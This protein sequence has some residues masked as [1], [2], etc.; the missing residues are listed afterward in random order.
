[1]S[2]DR[3]DPPHLP[4]HA[5]ELLCLAE[6]RLR[7]AGP[8][9]GLPASLDIAALVHN[10]SQLSDD[11]LR[12]Q[13]HIVVLPAVLA[14][15]CLLLAARELPVDGTATHKALAKSGRLA[16]LLRGLSGAA[17]LTDRQV[18]DACAL[19]QQLR[20]E[21][22]AVAAAAAH[23]CTVPLTSLVPLNSPCAPGPEPQWNFEF[24]AYRA[25]QGGTPLGVGELQPQPSSRSG[26]RNDR[27]HR[28]RAPAEA[29][30]G[31]R[32]PRDDEDGEVGEL[33]PRSRS[34]QHH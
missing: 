2:T 29:H 5:A 15:A 31:R 10:A 9:W 20:T 12:T 30:A 25:Q 34:Q 24:G 1:M 33:H 17:E 28:A 22:A 7:A 18:G 6:P 19:E 13:L 8:G 3:A 26:S 14:A 32:R 21:L 4:V 23:A 27:D 16:K 11:A